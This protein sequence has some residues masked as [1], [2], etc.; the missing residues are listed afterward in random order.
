MNKGNKNNKDL[1]PCNI[2]NPLYPCS[3]D[4]AKI[5]EKCLKWLLMDIKK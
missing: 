5:C 4:R 1:E 3:D 2:C